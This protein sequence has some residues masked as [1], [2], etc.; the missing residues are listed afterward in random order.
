MALLTRGS[1]DLFILS[2]AFMILLINTSC[3][4]TRKAVYFN[5]IQDASI[6]TAV[7]SLEPVIQKNDLLSITV[8]SLN[9]EANR[10]FNAPTSQ[11]TSEA[12]GYLVN[13][14]GNIEFPFLGLVK[15]AGLQKSQLKNNIAS[16]LIEKKLLVEPI[17]DLRYINFK[18]SVLG[19][20]ARPAV[21]VIPNEKVTL[22]EALGLAGDLTIFAR[23]DNILVIREEGDGTKVLKR[24]NLN[25]SELFTSPYYYLRSNDII[26]VE[27]NKTRIA[28]AS[29]SNQILPILFGGLSF[30]AIVVDRLT[31]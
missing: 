17:V 21:L 11:N 28:S 27:P 24:I 19:E 31:R 16:A 9:P 6:P 4:N 20:V 8:S 25:S 3:V 1:R 12:R 22:L 7:G 23:R 14:Q 30:A 2:Q 13:Q 5:N 15:A 29:R 10:I 26:Y 18:I